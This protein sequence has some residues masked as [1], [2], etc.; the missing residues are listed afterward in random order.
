MRGYLAEAK[1]NLLAVVVYDR[2]AAGNNTARRLVRVDVSTG[3][4]VE[5][6]VSK[7]ISENEPYPGVMRLN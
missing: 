3:V 4:Q 6:D 7:L 5:R 1:D 2:D